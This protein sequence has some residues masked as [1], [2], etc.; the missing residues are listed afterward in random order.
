MRQE[1]GQPKN[2]K[3]EYLDKNGIRQRYDGCSSYSLERA[4][5]FY[6]ETGGWEY[7]SSGY[8]TFHDGVENKWDE[9]HHFFVKQ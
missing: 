6:T 5:A 1:L 2:V 9:L 3:C 8:I 7:V 4:K